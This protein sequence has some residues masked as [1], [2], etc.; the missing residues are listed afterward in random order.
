[1]QQKWRFSERQTRSSRRRG[2]SSFKYF[3]GSGKNK[4]LVMSSKGAQEQ[5]RLAGRDQE[6]FTLPGPGILSIK[7][8]IET[9]M[10]FDQLQL[11]TMKYSN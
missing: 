7:D 10:P 4:N 6:Q 8:L 5:E 1:V 3:N 9:E 11:E 2:D